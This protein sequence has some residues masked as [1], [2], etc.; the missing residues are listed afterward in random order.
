MFNL[1]VKVYIHLKNIYCTFS[2]SMGTVAF[3]DFFMSNFVH[4]HTDW[5]YVFFEESPNS[6]AL[7]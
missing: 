6:R 2:V 5:I 3:E 4:L 1:N 7:C